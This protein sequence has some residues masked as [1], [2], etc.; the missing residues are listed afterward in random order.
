MVNEQQQALA[1]RKLAEI[2]TMPPVIA[3]ID[4]IDALGEEAS[5]RLRGPFVWTRNCR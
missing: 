5:K 4:R 1:A 3:S 2:E